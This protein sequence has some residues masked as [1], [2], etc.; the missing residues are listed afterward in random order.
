MPLE[1]KN[2]FN[3]L[4][5]RQIHARQAIALD[6]VKDML[7]VSVDDAAIL[8]RHYRFDYRSLIFIFICFFH[9]C[10]F[11]P[12]N[13][14]SNVIMIPRRILSRSVPFHHGPDGKRPS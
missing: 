2:S 10:F 5:A 11:Y 3:V 13:T 1:R 7:G 8:L 9:I 14:F 6:E 4:E 12:V